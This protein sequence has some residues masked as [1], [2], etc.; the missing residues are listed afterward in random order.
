MDKTFRPN[1]DTNICV[2][3]NENWELMMDHFD[4][5]NV[6]FD[7]KVKLLPLLKAILGDEQLS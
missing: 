1:L 7:R 3:G 6:H 5:L 4:R 2:I